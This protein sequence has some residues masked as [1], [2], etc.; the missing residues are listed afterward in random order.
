MTKIYERTLGEV[1]I[2]F[3]TTSE[4]REFIFDYTDKALQDF[5]GKRAW[6]TMPNGKQTYDYTELGF[7]LSGKIIDIKIRYDGFRYVSRHTEEVRYYS[8]E[9]TPAF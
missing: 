1:V 3:D 8:I 2:E 4:F 6:F 5:F 7:Y 9:Y